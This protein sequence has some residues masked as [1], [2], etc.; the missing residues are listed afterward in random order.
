MDGILLRKTH[1]LGTEDG[2]CAS[3]PLRVR[4]M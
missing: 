3:L 1:R 4:L 2:A